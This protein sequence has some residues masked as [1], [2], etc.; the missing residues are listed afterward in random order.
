MAQTENMLIYASK[1]LPHLFYPATLIL[2]LLV[3]GVFSKRRPPVI[4]AFILM[5]LACTPYISIALTSFI[6]KDQ[7]RKTPADMRLADAIV[8]LSG[9]LGVVNS[10]SGPIYEWGDPDR[11]FAG[12]DLMQA[13]KSRLVMFTGGK[14]P[15]Q[16]QLQSE[17]PIWQW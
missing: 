3:W 8:V 9:M 4:I 2:V 7:L 11:Y 5:W 17:G 16:S 15:S 13:R 6:E 14:F 12:L 1:I 10:Q